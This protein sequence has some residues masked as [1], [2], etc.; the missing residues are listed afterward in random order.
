MHY[1]NIS[2]CGRPDRMAAP[3]FLFPHNIHLVFVS[4]GRVMIMNLLNYAPIALNSVEKP[5]K[6]QPTIQPIIKY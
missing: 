2:V 1:I 4:Y 5:S 3:V 6:S